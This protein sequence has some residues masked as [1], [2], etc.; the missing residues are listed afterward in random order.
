M[1]AAFVQIGKIQ[2]VPGFWWLSLDSYVVSMVQGIE[3]LL[4]AFTPPPAEGDQK[5]S[6]NGPS[7]PFFS[8]GVIKK[9]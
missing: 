8:V 5:T 6:F 7:P 1:Q 9:T 2:D 3:S 4:W